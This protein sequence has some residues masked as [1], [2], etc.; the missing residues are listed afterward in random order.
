MRL[1]LQRPEGIVCD[2]ERELVAIAKFLLDTDSETVYSRVSR[3]RLRTDVVAVILYD[4]LRLS[5]DG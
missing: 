3:R 5:N 4:A 2:N 1:Q